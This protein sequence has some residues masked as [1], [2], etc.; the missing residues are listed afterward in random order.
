MASSFNGD[1]IGLHEPIPDDIY[2]EALVASQQ[3][4]DEED[5]FGPQP[6]RYLL[7]EHQKERQKR[8]L[9]IRRLAF[10]LKEERRDQSSRFRKLPPELI[11]KLM[12]HLHLSDLDS[13]VIS[14][15]IN[16]EIFGAS[17][18][19][20]YRGMEIEQLSDWKWLFGDTVHRTSAQMQHLK[21][22]I[23]T[24]F[25][26]GESRFD[27]EERLLEFLRMI[28]NKSFTGKENVIFLQEMQ[29]RVDTDIAAIETY[30]RRRIA[31]RTAMCLMSLS[32]RRPTVVKEEDRAD[33]APLVRCLTLSWVARSEL[34]VEQPASIQAEIQLLFM[35]VVRWFYLSLQTIL[36]WWTSKYYRRPGNHRKP[37][38]V[39]RWMSKL[40]TGLI[41]QDVAL[42]WYSV[43][44]DSDVELR[45]EQSSI[46]H[47]SLKLRRLLKVHDEGNVDV[48]EK[49]K[50]ALQFG[51]SIGIDLEGLVDGTWAGDL[52]DHLLGPSDERLIS[53]S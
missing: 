46:Y 42:Q 24:E 28:D 31:R 26:C 41:L 9:I 43:I 53:Y 38:E 6:K 33:N 18:T 40:V 19:A 32:F 35:I 15:A 10:R 14:S 25:C 27:F 48:L 8:E 12:Q 5:P 13:F 4:S 7:T 51:R 44:V 52:V 49:V 16:K 45:F 1:F 37:Q 34:I 29:D 47:V 20:I 11:L 39:K 3:D 50:D 30:T 36:G 2:E 22:A 17:E 23:C 21:D